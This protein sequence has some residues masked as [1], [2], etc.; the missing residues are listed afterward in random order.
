MKPRMSLCSI[1]WMHR[2]YLLTLELNSLGS[3]HNSSVIFHSQ[4]P[5]RLARIPVSSL[6]SF[7]A[8][9]IKFNSVDILP[10]TPHELE[11]IPLYCERFT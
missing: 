3:S 4:L 7:F 6:N 11:H 10:P 9:P 8:A 5:H 2:I 1:D